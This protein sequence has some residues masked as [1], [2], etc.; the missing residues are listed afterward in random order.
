MTGNTY[1]VGMRCHI[2]NYAEFGTITSQGNSHLEIE[3][4]NTD[5]LS[6]KRFIF[7]HSIQDILIAK[8]DNETMIHINLL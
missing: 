2:N 8:D 6:R 1:L 5:G 3:H 4:S 7:I